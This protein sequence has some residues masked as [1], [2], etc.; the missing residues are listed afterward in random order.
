MVERSLASNHVRK[1]LGKQT[2]R[3]QK[4]GSR[5][6]KPDKLVGFGWSIFEL[7]RQNT[8][9]GIDRWPER[10]LRRTCEIEFLNN[11]EI[12]PYEGYINERPIETAYVGFAREM[13][14]RHT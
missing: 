12:T 2:L 8:L 9:F 4:L 1:G 13:T 10:V 7:Y 14:H 3:A 5:P 6:N 11:R